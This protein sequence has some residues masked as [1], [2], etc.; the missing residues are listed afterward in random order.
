MLFAKYNF[1]LG[2]PFINVVSLIM[3]GVRFMEVNWIYE[4]MGSGELG[5]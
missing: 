1:V 3:I 4:E 2:L 5:V